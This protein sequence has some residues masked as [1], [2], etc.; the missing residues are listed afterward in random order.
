MSYA[1]LEEVI[2]KGIVGAESELNLA[3]QGGEPTL[4]GLS[5]YQ[6][7]VRLQGVHNTKNITIRNSIQTNGMAI[8][9]EFAKFF[10]E[11]NFLVGL[12]IDGDRESHE[13]NRDD[14]FKG[15]MNAARLFQKHSVEFNILC[16][17]TRNTARHIGRIYRFFRSSGFDY[18]QFIPCLDP[19]GEARGSRA[20]SLVPKDYGDF[21]CLLFDLWYADI[22]KGESVSIRLFDN[23]LM[24][25]AGRSAEACGL[26][27]SC[28]CQFVTEADG[29]VYPCDFYVSDRFRLGSILTDSIDELLCSDNCLEFVET[30]KGRAAECDA[31]QYLRFCYGGCRRDKDGTG[32]NKSYYC[33]ALKRFYEY[34]LPRFT[35]LFG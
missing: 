4:A 21:L 13:L 20:Y 7:A 34:S 23:V 25:L 8:D 29:S 16:V 6:E 30:S 2:K 3:F 19:E 31:C 32:V 14:S 26:G 35:K 12:S 33:E 10:H 5:F 17:V 1:T 11:N 22:I 15:A 18:L 27:G 24:V 9:D 28:S